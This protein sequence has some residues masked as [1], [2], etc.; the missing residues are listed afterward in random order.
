[1]Y[2]SRYQLT[3]GET[4][5]SIAFWVQEGGYI[6]KVPN[7][8]Q[9]INHHNK[10]EELSFLRECVIKVKPNGTVRQLA[11]SLAKQVAIV[12]LKQGYVG[13]LGKSLSSIDPR[14]TIQDLIYACEFYLGLEL[15]PQI[16]NNALLERARQRQQTLSKKPKQNKKKKK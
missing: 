3:P 5:N 8:S 15:V 13:H 16:V 1:M 14:L 4:L 6:K 12:A 11:R 7:R 9:A 2:A 10:L